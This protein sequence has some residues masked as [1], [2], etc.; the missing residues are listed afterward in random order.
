MKNLWKLMTWLVVLGLMTVGIYTPALAEETVDLSK[1][2]SITLDIDKKKEA[3]GGTFEAYRLASLEVMDGRYMF[4]DLFGDKTYELD[5]EFPPKLLEY[6][7]QFLSE[8]EMKAA[9]T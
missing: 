7:N 5:A 9:P 8:N 3:E 1:K 2:C 4:K 6:Y